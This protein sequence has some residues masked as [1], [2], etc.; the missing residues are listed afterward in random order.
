MGESVLSDEYDI[1]LLL[2]LT[3]YCYLYVIRLSNVMT[4]RNIMLVGVLDIKYV[5][6]L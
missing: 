1:H 2:K 4:T 6:P 5:Y 3:L